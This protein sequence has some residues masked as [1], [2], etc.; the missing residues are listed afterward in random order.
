MGPEAQTETQEVASEHQETL[1]CEGDRPLAQVAHRGCGVSM[2]GGS[3]K[4]SGHGQGQPT[5]GGPA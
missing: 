4:P 5:V 3:Q 1:H 2:F